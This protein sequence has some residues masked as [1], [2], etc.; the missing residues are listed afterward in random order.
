MEAYVLNP[1]FE[2]IAIVDSFESFIW[3]DRF[4]EAG[5]FEVYCFPSPD[6]LE[7]AVQDFYL[8]N[9]ESEHTMII[10]GCTITTDVEEGDRMI[11]KGRSLESILSRRIVWTQTT[12]SGNLQNEIIRLLEENIINPEI[13][14]RAIPNFI[15]EVSEDPMIT[16]LTVDVQ[17]TGDDLYEV[18]SDLCKANN[19]GFKIIL[20]EN[21]EFVFSLYA[22]MDRS[23]EQEENSYVVFSPNFENIINS[24]Y[25]ESIESLKNVTLVA[26]EGE[27]INRKT[28]T[29]GE[30]DGLLRRELYTDARDITSKNKDGTTISEE[31]YLKLLETRGQKK[32]DETSLFKAFEGE[33]DTLRTFVYKQ[34]FFIGDYVQVENEYGKS[35]SSL[36]SEIVWS[37]DAEGY[38]CYPTFIP[39]DDLPKKSE[40]EVL[41]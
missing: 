36:V 40:Q 20:N 23:Y 41:E 29:V 5:D 25:I 16:E 11:I 38:N 8:E 12:L 39:K 19:I 9:P 37:Q 34:D 35:G 15:V 33:V 28:V 4:Q 24:R 3:T 17:Y 7:N 27:D 6:M 30:V 2:R 32:L 22:G 10:E 1:N 14:E 18:I 13:P 31:D 21:F 26:G